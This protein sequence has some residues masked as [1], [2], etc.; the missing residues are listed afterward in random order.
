MP[1]LSAFSRKLDKHG[2][3]QFHGD[4]GTRTHGL[5]H[6]MQALSQLSY[7]PR[8]VVITTKYSIPYFLKK[9]KRKYKKDW[10]VLE[11]ANT[12]RGQP[13]S[14]ALYPFMIYLVISDHH[15]IFLHSICS[16][17]LLFLHLPIRRCGEA[18]ARWR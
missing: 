17:K 3:L 5:L 9:W 14:A 1:Y 11:A 16:D 2:I 8:C 7:I 10:W 15:G 4:N 12:E 6:A 18:P 13:H